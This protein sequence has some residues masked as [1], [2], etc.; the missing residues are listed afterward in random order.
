MARLPA[1]TNVIFFG[2]TYLYRALLGGGAAVAVA[3]PAATGAAAGAGLAAASAAL[4]WAAGFALAPLVA[5]VIGFVG[6]QNPAWLQPGLDPSSLSWGPPT[7]AHCASMAGLPAVQVRSATLRSDRAGVR[8]PEWPCIPY[9]STSWWSLV[10][11]P[12]SPPVHQHH[13]LPVQFLCTGTVDG[14]IKFG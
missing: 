12:S 2:P 4:P 11:S 6:A 9:A 3:A 13:L 14:G 8:V 1:T 7:A 10:T 5:N